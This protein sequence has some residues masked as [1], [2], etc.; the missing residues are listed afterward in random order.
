MIKTII[1]RK[2]IRQMSRSISGLFVFLC[3]A[4]SASSQQYGEIGVHFG[5]TYYLGE[6][7]WTQHFYTPRVNYGAFY[8]QHFNSRVALK[9][10]AFYSHI[11][12]DD[13]NSRWQY[14]NLR[15]Y[16]FETQ[17]TEGAVQVEFNFLVYEIGEVK[18]KFFTPYVDL[19]IGVCYT[20]DAQ[21]KFALVIPGAV[22]IKVNLTER[23][24]FG[25]EWAFRK[26]NTDMLD[27][28][29]GEDYDI[30]E[31]ARVPVT[32]SNRYKQLGFIT[33]DDWYSYA[34]ITLSYA[35]RISGFVCHAYH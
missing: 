19:G 16:A 30:Y 28:V 11:Q 18:K 15:N 31:E 3:L 33:N 10:G 2:I 12:G 5:G 9:F 20:A 24:V 22:G 34:G 35:F 27:N 8:K 6:L 32:A 25:A 29:T 23:I 1:K 4:F 14:Q 7:N 13:A 26:T 21:N 17:L